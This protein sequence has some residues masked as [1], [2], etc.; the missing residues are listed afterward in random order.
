MRS[1]GDAYARTEFRLHK[2]AKPA[3]REAFMTAWTAYRDSLQQ[4]H[5][6]RG[7]TP[8]D[9]EALSDEQRQQLIILREEA[10]KAR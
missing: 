2:S 6:F 5:T 7:L 8:E 1:L 4:A 10:K 3:H 9:F